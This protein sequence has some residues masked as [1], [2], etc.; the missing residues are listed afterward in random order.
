MRIP[1]S[2]QP[3]VQRVQLVSIAQCRHQRV[4]H[5]QTVSSRTRW[6]RLVVAA[7]LRARQG[8]TARNRRLR[9]PS[10]V[11]GNTKAVLHNRAVCPVVLDL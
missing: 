6:R 2:V 7:A 1:P 8:N 10:A 5:A 9:A 11:L 4:Q 3:R